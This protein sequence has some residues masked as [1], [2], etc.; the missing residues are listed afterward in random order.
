VAVAVAESEAEASSH[1][2]DAI[3]VTCIVRELW[4]AEQGGQDG[5]NSNYHQQLN[6]CKRA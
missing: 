5:N 2:G 1:G 3:F 4:V 6:Q